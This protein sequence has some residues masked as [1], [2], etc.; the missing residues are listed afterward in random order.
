MNHPLRN[1]SSLRVLLLRLNFL[2]HTLIS[3]NVPSTD[4]RLTPKPTSPPMTRDSVS[5]TLRQSINPL[6]NR[7]APH[8]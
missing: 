5:N 6:Y 2:H 3:A 1:P 4:I 7:A 8:G